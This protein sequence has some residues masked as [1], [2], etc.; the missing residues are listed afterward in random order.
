MML[1]KKVQ[2]LCSFIPGYPFLPFITELCG[3][4]IVEH[5]QQLSNEQAL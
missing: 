2:Y 5:C 3:I 1:L 4:S